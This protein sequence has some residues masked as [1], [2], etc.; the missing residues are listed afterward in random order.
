[1]ACIDGGMGSFSVNA[2]TVTVDFRGRVMMV[3]GGNGWQL[4]GGSV[5]AGEQPTAAAAARTLQMTGVPVG[6][7]R[8][9]GVYTDT[10]ES[11]VMFVF[12]ARPEA[13]G[14]VVEGFDIEWVD[15]AVAMGRADDHYRPQITDALMGLWTPR[16]RAHESLAEAA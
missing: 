11:I 16:F 6:I 9:T 3:R 4:P 7:A 5:M 1:M 13:G 14:R 2:S 10:R 15:P 8:C 12:A